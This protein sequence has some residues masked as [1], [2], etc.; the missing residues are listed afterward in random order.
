MVSDRTRWR[1]PFR[2]APRPFV[3][4]AATTPKQAYFLY[5]AQNLVWVWLGVAA[6]VSTAEYF[7]RPA[8]G[9]VLVTSSETFDVVRA[10]VFAIGGFLIATGVWTIRRAFEVM[11]H[12]LFTTGVL[13]NIAALFSVPAVTAGGIVQVFL[14]AGVGF[15]SA[16]RAYFIVRWIGADVRSGS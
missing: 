11:G 8:L 4:F 7:A 13:L 3:A 16:Y 5:R 2:E 14:L 6:V 10:V 9:P 15:A 1:L 12:I